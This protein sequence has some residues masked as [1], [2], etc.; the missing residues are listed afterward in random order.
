MDKKIDLFEAIVWLF[1]ALV[2]VAALGVLFTA[3]KKDIIK[4]ETQAKIEVL[5]YEQTCVEPEGV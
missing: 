1:I 2:F 4:A 5:Q 3:V